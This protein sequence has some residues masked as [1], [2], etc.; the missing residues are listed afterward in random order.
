MLL[1]ALFSGGRLVADRCGVT[2][3]ESSV[4]RINS[5]VYIQGDERHIEWWAVFGIGAI[6]WL[7][8]IIFV[9]VV[10]AAV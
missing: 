4:R 6:F 10:Y 7:L 8:T 3:A 9:S 5:M 2:V 1:V